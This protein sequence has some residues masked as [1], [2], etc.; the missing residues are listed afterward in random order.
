MDSKAIQILKGPSEGLNRCFFLY[1]KQGRNLRVYGGDL[2]P[3][4][5]K[6]PLRREKTATQCIFKGQHTG[7]RSS[8]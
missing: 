1:H 5:E 7:S 8:N 6:L 4:P 2:S 3:N